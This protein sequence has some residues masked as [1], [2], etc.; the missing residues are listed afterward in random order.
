M[1]INIGLPN[2]QKSN[3]W[4]CNELVLRKYFQEMFIKQKNLKLDLSNYKVTLEELQLKS[5]HDIC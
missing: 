4:G 2:R 1:Q 5:L 3:G